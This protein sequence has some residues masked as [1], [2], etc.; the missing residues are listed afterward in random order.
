LPQ[1]I[2][3]FTLILLL[4]LGYLAYTTL[5]GPPAPTLAYTEFR[6]LVR[7]GKVAE[8]TLEET[9]MLGLLK[10]PERFPTPQGERVARRFQ[11][12]LSLIHI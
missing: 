2:N 8:V 6:E 12:P 9:R 3:P 4:L 10:E 11:V 7:Q 1:R 5:T